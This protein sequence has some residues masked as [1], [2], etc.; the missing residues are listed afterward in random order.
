M[1]KGCLEFL[2]LDTAPY[3]PVRIHRR[4]VKQYLSKDVIKIDDKLLPIEPERNCPL[5]LIIFFKVDVRSKINSR[6]KLVSSWKPFN[7][8]VPVER[9]HLSSFLSLFSLDGYRIVPLS[10]IIP[11][12]HVSPLSPYLFSESAE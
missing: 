9:K 12:N 6:G 10:K 1:G 4:P 2:G 8:S 3:P 11:S 5:R 7:L